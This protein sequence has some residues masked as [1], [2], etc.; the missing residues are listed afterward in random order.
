MSNSLI[1]VFVKLNFAIVFKLNQLYNFSMV[2]IF[3]FFNKF[4]YFY[5]L[6]IKFCNPNVEKK[7]LNNKNYFNVKNP[8]YNLLTV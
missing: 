3:N 5:L 8:F 7:L 2:Q 1:Y 6:V 4:K